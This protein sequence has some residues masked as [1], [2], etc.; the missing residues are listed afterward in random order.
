LAGTAFGRYRIIRELGRGAMAVVYLAEDGSL[1]REVAIKSLLPQYAADTA[2]HERFLRE[3]RILARVR[4]QSI[5]PIYD[6]GSEDDVPY[7]V[8]EYLS[9]GTLEDRI[10]GGHLGLDE[11]LEVLTRV[12]AELHSVGCQVHFQL[13]RLEGA[14][15]LRMAL[16]G[17]GLED[18]RLPRTF[19]PYYLNRLL[20]GS[21]QGLS[22][23]VVQTAVHAHGGQATAR[24]LPD[25]SLAVDLLLPLQPL[26]AD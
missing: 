22:L 21:S 18:W 25:G 12:A 24:R 10:R 17:P 20:R 6:F 13:A 1:M 11:S 16:R 2:F 9:G 8:M 4:H 5:V 14:L 23:F 7:L 15:R 26:P 19:E 3:G